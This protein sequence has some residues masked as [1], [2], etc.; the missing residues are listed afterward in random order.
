M[1]HVVHELGA[2]ALHVARAEELRH[3]NGVV[4][5]ME[6]LQAQLAVELVQC[7]GQTGE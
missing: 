5:G 7:V 1:L 4:F 6:H 3:G 2:S